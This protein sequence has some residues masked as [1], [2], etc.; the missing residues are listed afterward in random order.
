[1]KR[2][3]RH[4]RGARGGPTWQMRCGERLVLGESL[5]LDLKAQRRQNA[6]ASLIKSTRRT[7]ATQTSRAQAGSCKLRCTL[8]WRDLR[9]R[10]ILDRLN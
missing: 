6:D 2:D 1:M 9:A 4:A 10:A 7:F 5:R 3:A 8:D